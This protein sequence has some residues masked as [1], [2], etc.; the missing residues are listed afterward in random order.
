MERKV[1][2]KEIVATKFE[3]LDFVDKLLNLYGE[4]TIEKKDNSYYITSID[5]QTTQV[6]FEEDATLKK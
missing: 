3:A 2:A 1:F 6:T 5:G 4:S